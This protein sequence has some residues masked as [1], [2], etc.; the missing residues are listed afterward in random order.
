M[1]ARAGWARPSHADVC[2]RVEWQGLESVCLCM[3][4]RVSPVPTDQQWW[5]R[6]V[7]GG[8]GFGAPIMLHGL[9]HSFASL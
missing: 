4:E 7:R 5:R 3:R 2:L 6:D 9:L 8:E 1:F